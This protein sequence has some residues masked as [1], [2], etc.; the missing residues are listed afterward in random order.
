MIRWLKL[1]AHQHPQRIQTRE[2]QLAIHTQWRIQKH[3]GKGFYR[4]QLAGW[5]SGNF[6]IPSEVSRPTR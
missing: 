4:S 1:Q 2:L 6:H 5:T 3:E